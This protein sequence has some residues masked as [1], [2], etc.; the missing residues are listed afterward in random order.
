MTWI[1][2]S[3][4]MNSM[5]QPKD[6]AF[7]L[8]GYTTPSVSFSRCETPPISLS[9]WEIGKYAPKSLKRRDSPG[10]PQPMHARGDNS[11][12]RASFKQQGNNTKQPPQNFPGRIAAPPS[13]H[14]TQNRVAGKFIKWHR[15]IRGSCLRDI[16][17]TSCK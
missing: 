6:W 7:S 1:S 15:P 4:R 17:Q 5:K 11:P 10:S 3:G 9:D 8:V 13:E 16:L 14:F 2:F 12:C